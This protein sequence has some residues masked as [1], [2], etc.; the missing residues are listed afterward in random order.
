MAAVE[1]AIISIVLFMILFGT[2]AF[3]IT[4]SKYQVMQGAAREGGRLLAVRATPDEARARVLDAAGS[5]AGDIGAINVSGQCS[6]STIGQPVTISW[7]Q[8]FQIDIPF[9]P[10]PAVTRTISA[11]FRCE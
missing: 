3:G 4:Y 11:V 2:I 6:S 7:D 10:L 9:V 5:Y 1:F 8:T